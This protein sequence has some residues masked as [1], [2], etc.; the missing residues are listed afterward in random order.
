MIRWIFATKCN[1]ALEAA[2]A[3]ANDSLMAVITTALP[4]IPLQQGPFVG[5]LSADEAA[6]E[7]YAVIRPTIYSRAVS[8]L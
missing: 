6:M 1:P 3:H 2:W 4:E 5:T 7:S 8:V